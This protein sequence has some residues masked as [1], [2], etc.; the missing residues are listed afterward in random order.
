MDLSFLKKNWPSA[1]VAREEISKFTGGAIS[2]RTMANLDCLGTGVPDRFRISRKV[3]YR[4][5]SLI[6]WLESRSSKLS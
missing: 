4:V 1:I 6:A 5:D 2:E 3:V